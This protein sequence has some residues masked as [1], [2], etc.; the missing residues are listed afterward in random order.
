MNK[1]HNEDPKMTEALWRHAAV[2][3]IEQ[4]R[5]EGVTL[6]RALAMASQRCWGNCSYAA[7]TLEEWYYR[8]RKEGF[9][10]LRSKE[11]SDRG[12]M[13]AV[14]PEVGEA[15]VKLRR[16]YPNLNVKVL[17]K[18]MIKTGVLQKGTCSLSS[19]Y[20]FLAREGLDT[21]SIKA[22]S[23]SLSGP[24]KAFEFAHAN[25]LWMTDM[26]YGPVLKTSTGKTIRTRLFALLDDCSRLIPHAEYYA[27]ERLDCFL[28][29]FKKGVARRGVPLKLY[30]DRGKVFTS[31]HLQIVC[32]NLGTRLTHAKPYHA[33]SKGK[34][35]R[36]FL[37]LQGDFEAALVFNKV[38]DLDALNKAL[39]EWIE[40]DYH[41]R[42]HSALNKESPAL[43][44]Q[45]RSEFIR[46]V[47]PTVDLEA[48]FL[49]RMQRRVRQDATIT[50]NALLWEV[51]VHLRG[52][53]VQLRYNPFT[54]ER[55]EV[56]HKDSFV[57]HAKKCDKHEN[58][59]TYNRDN[60]SR[61]REK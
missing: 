17:L 53:N 20:R 9:S 19:I 43:R 24:T 23:A 5:S 21:R 27:S 49:S 51:P 42:P 50:I 31:R 14:S 35:E 28:D 61:S 46:L 44:F 58:A 2:S 11:R 12:K 8:Y 39:W 22:G 10:A 29:T 57:C 25:E 15:L 26:M 37:S 18:E 40:T 59:H 48:C 4:V 33:W 32:A 34:I 52:H 56:W 16:E 60:Y 36:F 38:H 55:V 13:T 6:R 45:K 30:T 3:F 41:Q 54:Y 1:N 47:D 7:A